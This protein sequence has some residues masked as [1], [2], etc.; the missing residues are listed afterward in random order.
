LVDGQPVLL[1]SSQASC[2]PNATPLVIMTTQTRV[3]GI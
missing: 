2:V 1:Q 3:S